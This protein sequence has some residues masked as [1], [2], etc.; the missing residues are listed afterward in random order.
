MTK[1]SDFTSINLIHDKYDGI[2]MDI[3]TLPTDIKKIENEL[4]FILENIKDKKLLWIKFDIEKSHIIPIFTKY[5]FVFHHCNEK[6][7]TMVKKLTNTAIIPTAINHTLGVG[8][9][10]I[11][12]NKLLVIKDKIWKKFKLP[13][14]YIDDTENIS[15]ALQREVFEET[16]IEI[17]LDSIIS[18]GHSYPSQFE[19][20]NLYIVC[21]A[22]ALSKE[23]NIVDLDE[24]IEV[25]WMDLDEYFEC[26]DIHIYNKDL[27]KTA[28]KER[29]LKLKKY[30]YFSNSDNQNEYYF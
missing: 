3:T 19:K 1:T 11:E 6:N 20:S 26:E 28:I 2:T 21:S 8:A 29:G 22:T 7:I 27:V 25:K 18:L 14:G 9:V 23:I 24:I 12:E 5:D 30:N 16:G 17:E 10:I 13:G 4:I 15:Q